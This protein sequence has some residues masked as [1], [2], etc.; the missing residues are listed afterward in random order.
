MSKPIELTTLK[1]IRAIG[2]DFG[3]TN[4]VAIYREN[5]QE[6]FKIIFPSVVYFDEQGVNVQDVLRPCSDSSVKISSIKRILGRTYEEISRL[7]F[8]PEIRNKIICEGG[9]V[10]ILCHNKKYTPVEV[11]ACIFSYIK[12]KILSFGVEINHAVVTIPAYFNHMQRMAVM[13]AAKIGGFEVLRTL[14][15]PT[16]A[17]LA[18]KLHHKRNGKFLIYDLGG[19]TFDVSVVK[20]EDGVVQVIAVDGD[21]HLGGD[22][23]D[24]EIA[25]EM[26]VSDK[27]ARWLKEAFVDQHKVSELIDT[28]KVSNAII[29]STEKIVNKTISILKRTFEYDSESN[30][31]ILVGG[32][33]KSLYLRKMLDCLGLNILCDID[34]DL[35]VAVGASIH[36]NELTERSK[37]ILLDVVP[38]SIGVEMY[39][40]FVER[41]I[42]RN[43]PVPIQASR[44]FTTYADNQTAMEFRIVQGER[45]FAKDCTE[46][47]LFELNGISPA[48]AGTISV[49]LTCY[50]DVNGIIYLTARQ[51]NGATFSDLVIKNVNDISTQDLENILEESFSFLRQDFH[52]RSIAEAVLQA[53]K[54]IKRLQSLEH[55]SDTE[56]VSLITQLQEAIETKNADVIISLI[57]R[58]N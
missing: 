58:K 38:L 4:S 22:D 32:S 26:G 18:Y 19:G 31:M 33:T 51:H 50:V 5:E 16:A 37:N 41:I 11:A 6:I 57:Q 29:R 3:T 42:D 52:E 30:E 10:K 47:G 14:C 54:E 1:A 39:G 20:I 35:T 27:E 45:E 8:D 40:G 23:I 36:A 34:P 21:S 43:S 25:V 7:E 44:T 49:E 46:I 15:E 12:S 13:N 9:L 2:I 17:A 53:E 56:Y 24:R 48:K 55:Q 28:E